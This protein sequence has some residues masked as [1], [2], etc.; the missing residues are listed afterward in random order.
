MRGFPACYGHSILQITDYRVHLA[1]FMSFAL[2]HAWHRQPGQDLPNST[3]IFQVI[4]DLGITPIPLD[5]F[6]SM[7]SATSSSPLY[8]TNQTMPRRL[9]KLVT[10][11]IQLYRIY[12]VN[13]CINIP[14]FFPLLDLVPF[15]LTQLGHE[16]CLA[17]NTL[18]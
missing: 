11:N 7:P 17:N 18:K 5:M 9:G 13:E 14:N 16:A 6:L 2:L 15:L 3:F 4:P 12:S 8:S 10:L 1:S